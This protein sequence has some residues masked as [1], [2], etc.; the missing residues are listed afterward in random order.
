VIVRGLRVHLAIAGPPSG[1]PVILQHGWP[2]HWYEWRH[3]MGPLAQAGYRAIAPDFRGFGWSEYPPDEDFRKDTLAD[4]VIA[5]CRTLGYDRVSYV[6]HDWGCWVGWLLCLREPHLVERAVM[7]SVRAPIPPDTIDLAALARLFRLAYQVPIAAPMPLVAKRLT[8]RAIGAA[9]SRA[10]DF[11][12][13]REPYLIA[14]SQRSVMRA[15]TL[16]YRDFLLRELPGLIGGRYQGRHIGVPVRFL[17]GDRDPFYY[18]EMVE[19]QAPHFDDYAGESLTGVGHFIP[20]QAPDLL[21]ERV[22]SFLGAGATQ[23]AVAT[24]R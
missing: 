10:G 21:S 2:Q 9:L 16:L 3:L 14:L 11:E 18:P 24:P 5:L 22:L 20:E 19:E 8:L 13:D 1:P 15:T 4:D 7:L 23:G 6:G 17:V 12:L